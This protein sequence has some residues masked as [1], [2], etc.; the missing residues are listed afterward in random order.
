LGIILKDDVVAFGDTICKFS[1]IWYR[2]T[3]GYNSFLSQT[4]PNTEYFDCELPRAMESGL[5]PFTTLRRAFLRHT[6]A[7]SMS[8]DTRKGVG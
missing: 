3:L 8:L 5:T 4:L 2:G 1:Y 7:D 6:G